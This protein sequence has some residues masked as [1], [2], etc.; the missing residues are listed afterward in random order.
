MNKGAIEKCYDH[1]D[2]S[3]QVNLV[4]QRLLASLAVR[5]T[6][7][8]GKHRP[9]TVTDDRLVLAEEPAVCRLRLLHPLPVLSNSTERHS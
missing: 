9:S 7:Q 3:A 2:H 1:Y 8:G 6:K 4:A 5:P